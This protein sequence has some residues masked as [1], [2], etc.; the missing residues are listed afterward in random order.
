MRD[1]LNDAREPW[2]SSTTK[3]PCPFC[4]KPT[5][6]YDSRQMKDVRWRRR[7]CGDGHTFTTW[8]KAEKE[9]S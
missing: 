5:L 1:E 7:V 2:K 4:G 9:E 8:E 3:F 6:V